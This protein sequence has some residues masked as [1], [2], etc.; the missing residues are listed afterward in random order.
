MS[1]EHTNNSSFKCKFFYKIENSFL[2][3]DFLGMERNIFLMWFFAKM[4][5]YKNNRFFLL[6]T[7]R[8]SD[9]FP[10]LIIF[11]QVPFRLVFLDL[12]PTQST[13]FQETD[14]TADQIFKF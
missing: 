11:F 1:F 4:F 10:R 8:R 2:T 6:K 5:F 9:N 14:P 7:Q 12:I 13:G 3:Y